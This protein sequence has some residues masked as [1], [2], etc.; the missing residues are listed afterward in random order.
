MSN[1]FR[2]WRAVLI[3]TVTALALVLPQGV[4]QAAP[5]PDKI[6]ETVLAE[7]AAEDKAT[8]WVSLKS[9]ADLSAARKATTKDREGQAGLPGQDRVSPRR[10]RRACASSSPPQRVRLHPVLDRQRRPGDR[11]RQAGREI[12]KRP[13]VE[14]IDA[15]DRVTSCPSPLP[16][17]R[18][19][20]RSTPSSGTST[21]STPPRSGTSSAYAVR[22]SSS[23]TSTPASSS[24]TRRW[25][26][27]YRGTSAD[28]SVRPQLQLVRPGRASARPPRRA[29]TTATAPTPWAPWSATT[30]AATRSAS[31]RARSGSPPRAASPT[32]APTP[33]CSPP[34]SGSSRPTDLQRRQPAPRPGPGRRQ[35]LLGRPPAS[36]PGT[37]RSSRRG[38]PRASS[39]PSP[40][41]TTGP[42]CNTSGSP[43]HLH[44]LVLRPARSTSTTPSPSFSSRGTGESGEIKPNLAAPGVNV[45]SSVPGGGYGTISGTSMASPHTAG[46]VALIWSASPALRRATST[47]RGPARPDRDRRQRHAP[48][49]APLPTTT[50]S[51]RA[52]STRSPRSA[53]P[54][55][56]PLG[57]LNGTVTT[58]GSPLAG[59]AVS[60]HRADEPHRHHRR[61]RDLLLPGAERRRLRVTVKKFGY[62]DATGN[63][64]PSWRDQT[65]TLDLSLTAAADAHAERHGHRRWRA[66]SPGARSTAVGTP[67]SDVTDAAGAYSITRRRATTR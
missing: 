15:D 43:G 8:F 61:G 13:E 60:R 34:A 5:D 39:R 64:S 58:G 67:L 57:A 50:S 51:V 32:P 1:T 21:A 42:G 44:R 2:N 66:R 11:R 26:T 46:T 47:R 7:L 28:G 63:A 59:R 49:A 41:A 33:R 27:K 22:A 6:D 31:P 30:A 54:R 24:T 45:R 38:W 40:T 18:R 62:A 9:D 53:P 35:Q 19:R 36:T 3:G 55:V 14:R 37:R 23:P 29:T 12:A 56:G 65:A 10:R 52:G 4:A 48:A 25:P 16:G 20:R 17:T